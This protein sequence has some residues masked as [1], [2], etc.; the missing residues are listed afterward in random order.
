M[1]VTG[2]TG[3]SGSGKT[4]AAHLFETHGFY[5]IDCDRLVHEKVYKTKKLLDEISNIFGARYVACGVLDRRALG[6]LVFSDKS[7]YNRLMTAVKP[8]VVSCVLSELK[9]AENR[10]VIL[11]APL[12]FDYELGGICRQTV[13]VVASDTVGRIM[14]RDGISEADARARLSNQRPASYYRERCDFI[15]ENDFDLN[16]LSDSVGKIADVIKAGVTA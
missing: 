12:L 8:Y 9:A 4:T 5:H 2:L 3:Q 14:E 16:S 11:D 10:L 15:I 1:N 13:G 6:R 7:A